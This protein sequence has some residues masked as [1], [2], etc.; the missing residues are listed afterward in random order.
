M[1]NKKRIT[2][3]IALALCAVMVFSDQALSSEK[4]P[5]DKVVDYAYEILNYTWTTDGYIVLHDGTACPEEVNGK[6]SFTPTVVKGTIKG[7]PYTLSSNG[8]GGGAEKTFSEYKELSDYERKLVS[9]RYWYGKYNKTDNG[10]R[11]GMKYGMSCT[12]F[13]W[14]CISQALAGVTRTGWCPSIPDL[15]DVTRTSY[16]ELQK[17]D[18]LWKSTHVMLVVANNPSSSRL[19]VIEQAPLSWSSTQSIESIYLPPHGYYDARLY[20]SYTVGTQERTYSYSNISSYTPYRVNYS[21]APVVA[22]EISPGLKALTSSKYAKVYTSEWAR[23]TALYSDKDFRN[24]LYPTNWIDEHEECRIIGVGVNSRGNAYAQIKFPLS[25][26]TTFKEGYVDLQKAF[27]PGAKT[28]GA[29]KTTRRGKNPYRRANYDTIMY[30]AAVDANTDTYLLTEVN[31]W[32]QVLYETSSRNVWR[33]VWMPSWDYEYMFPNVNN[34]SITG[35]NN[36]PASAVAGSSYRGTVTATGA[37]PITWTVSRGSSTSSAEYIR[38]RLPSGL[39][40]SGSGTTGTISG[41]PSHTSDGQS[42]F[43]PLYYYFKVTASNSYDSDSKTYYITVW[44]PPVFETSATLAKGDVN[45]YYSQTITAKGT[46]FSMS[47][48][49][50]EGKLPPGLKFTASDSKRTATISGTP[51]QA[52]YYRFK[53]R[54]YNLVGNSNTTTTRWFTITVGNVAA[55]Y[56]NSSNLPFTYNFMNAPAGKSY[57]DWVGVKDTKSGTKDPNNYMFSVSDGELPPG[58]YLDEESSSTYTAG[59]I[60]LRGVPMKAGTYNFT[61]KAKR[62]SDGGYNTKSFT[63]KITSAATTPWRNYNMSTRYY[64]ICTSTSPKLRVSY[65]DYFTV[66][67]GSSPYTPSVVAGELPPGM[68]LEQSGNRTYLTG[69]PKRY[70]QFSFTVRVTGSNGGYVDKACNVTV[71][72]NPLYKSGGTSKASKPKFTSKLLPDAYIG[73]MWEATLD[74]SGTEPIAWSAEDTLPEWLT[75]EEST[76]RI[77][78]I[79]MEKGKYRFRIK[80]ENEIGSVT[81]TFKV[82]VVRATPAISTAEVPEGYVGVPYETR[83]EASGTDPIKWSKIGKLPS[84]LKLDKTMGIISG[85]PRKSGSFDITIKAK[86]KAGTDMIPLTIVIRPSADEPETKD[87]EEEEESDDDNDEES[88]DLTADTTDTT[89][90]VLKLESEAQQETVTE[91]NGAGIFS[92]KLY[93]LIGGEKLEGAVNTESG[94]PLAFEIGAW[95][96]EYGRN[97]DVSGETVFVNDEPV[98]S[99]DISDEGIFTLPDGIVSGEITVYVSAQ[100]E[101]REIRTLEVNA[102]VAEESQTIAGAV[103]G[104]NEQGSTGGCNFSLIG[105]AGLIFCGIAAAGKKQ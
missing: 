102:V 77:Y 52:G 64:F 41:Y 42:S 104:G 40:I 29:R 18:I 61:L 23:Y 33:I 26:G 8:N 46:E 75:L 87:D 39:S 74:A 5:R 9:N 30:S 49:I 88:G 25:N 82:K 86:N 84:G 21:E 32:C 67:G 35:T 79:P 59:K 98:G 10:Y 100:A 78:G 44:E 3:L 95:V 56:L 11:V 27:V 22:P 1:I 81:K 94:K 4:S 55:E 43:M 48:K 20:N 38:L 28:D 58:L 54:C 71:V 34:V 97:V 6:P 68:T 37:T 15:W 99:A 60:Y 19:T 80:A 92:T 90:P 51:T 36:I 31:G 24:S 69:V 73:S 17:G 62:I 13:V 66:S 50:I 72:N 85:T 47:W 91:T 65:S 96:D 76:G 57:S 70:G 14:N 101:G 93:A 53:V 89:L 105:L 12:T 16:S 45:Q 103:S 2:G 7:I 83:L 63:V